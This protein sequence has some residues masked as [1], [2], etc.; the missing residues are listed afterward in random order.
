MQQN[1]SVL[2]LLFNGFH[3]LFGFNNKKRNCACGGKIPERVSYSYFY[4]GK[5]I[6]NNVYDKYMLYKNFVSLTHVPENKWIKNNV[7]ILWCG[8]RYTPGKW[9]TRQG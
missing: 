1:S 2:N 3:L 5:P 4:T 9:R 8:C 6:L 7:L